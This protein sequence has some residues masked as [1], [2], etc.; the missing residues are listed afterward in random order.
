M[1][2]DS[3]FNRIPYG[4]VADYPVTITADTVA[5][6]TTAMDACSARHGV[7]KDALGEMMLTI[8]KAGYG[9]NAY[10]AATLRALADLIESDCPR[11]EDLQAPIPLTAE[12]EIAHKLDQIIRELFA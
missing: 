1:S 6:A 12:E 7:T 4:A 9:R 10:N 3:P 11:P 2:P 5:Q 8:I